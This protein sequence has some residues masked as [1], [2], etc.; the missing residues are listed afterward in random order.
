MPIYTRNAHCSYC[1]HPFA[2]NAPWPRECVNCHNTSFI[3]PVPVAVILVPV[4]DGILLVRRNIPPQIGELALPGG[5][6]NFGETW[7]AAG[8]R[9]M[10]EETGLRLDAAEIQDF[11]T[12]SPPDGHMVLIFGLARPRT[13]GDLPPFV[14]NE[15][16]QEC[17][18][19]RAPQTLA[20]PLHTQVLN[21]YF[22]QRDTGH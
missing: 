14:P 15:E 8:A 19:V 18:I 10:W 13:A 9:E 3:N 21:A 16:T 6:V 4:D 12:L 22:A 5:Y 20:F 7:Q 11:L 17:V 1:G 2:A